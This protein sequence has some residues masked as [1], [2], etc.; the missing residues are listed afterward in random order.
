[1]YPGGPQDL[2]SSQ[3][4][5]NHWTEHMGVQSGLQERKAPRLS[6]TERQSSCLP[7]VLEHD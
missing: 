6:E 1:M 7:G 5:K 4:R 3:G 2:C